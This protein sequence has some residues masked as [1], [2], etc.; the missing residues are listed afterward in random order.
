MHRFFY[1]I[2][3]AVTAL[4]MM[5]GPSY[6]LDIQ[7][8]RYGMHPDKVRMVIEFSEATEYRVFALDGPYRIVIDIPEASWHADTIE[9]PLA[10]GVKNVRQALLQEGVSRIVVEVDFP[11]SDTVCF[12]PA[13]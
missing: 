4:F 2:M 13:G 1:T 9:K 6:A 10:S 3:M 7:D 8:V 5:T 12:F 11:F